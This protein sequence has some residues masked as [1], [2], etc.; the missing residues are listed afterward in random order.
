M[1]VA[2]QAQPT[3]GEFLKPPKHC[4]LNFTW[5]H[6]LFPAS[7]NRCAFHPYTYSKVN[8]MKNI[9]TIKTVTFKEVNLPYFLRWYQ[10]LDYDVQHLKVNSIE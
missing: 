6:D 2:P 1:F 5:L 9:N 8:Q 7:K 10:L 3:F 4:N